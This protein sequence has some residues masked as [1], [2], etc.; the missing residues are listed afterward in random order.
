ML[1]LLSVPGA[2]RGRGGGAADHEG[3]AELHLPGGGGRDAADR[4]R[5]FADLAPQRNFAPVARA[6]GLEL[7]DCRE[8][9]LADARALERLGGL[10]HLVEDRRYRCRLVA[11]LALEPGRQITA[12][13][14]KAGE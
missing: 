14:R 7:V 1:L 10:D 4:Q 3:E 5:A 12:P 2:Q 9:L 6:L 11:A 8:R 13:G